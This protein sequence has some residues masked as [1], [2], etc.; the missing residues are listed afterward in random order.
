MGA[1]HQGDGDPRPDERD[2]SG[3]QAGSDRPQ[4]A[5]KRPTTIVIVD[6]DPGMRKLIEHALEEAPGRYEVLA[7]CKNGEEAIEAARK[8]RPDVLLLDID[9]PLMN[10]LEALPILSQEVPETRV[11]I[12]SGSCSGARF[13]EAERNG[14]AACLRKQ[15]DFTVFT[16]CLDAVLKEDVVKP[17]CMPVFV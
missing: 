13:D 11:I 3:S 7:H 6:D 16:D 5:L 15:V 2:R 17:E 4:R 9:M 10:G 12:C 14:A 8:L 1:V